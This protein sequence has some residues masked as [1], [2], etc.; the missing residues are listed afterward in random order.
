MRGIAVRYYLPIELIASAILAAIT[1]FFVVAASDLSTTWMILILGALVAATATFW[2]GDITRVLL[3]GFAFA[4]AFDLQKSLIA[5]HGNVSPGLS[6]YPPDVFLAP[7]L[8]VWLWQKMVIRRERFVAPVGFKTATLFYLWTWVTALASPEWY[9]GILA[10]LVVTRYF[11]AYI[12]LADIIRDGQTFRGVLL[13]I[14]LALL[15]N[16]A[17]VSAQFV[18]RS[19]LALQGAK[20][21]SLGV[22]LTFATEGVS[23][24][25]PA[26]FLHHPNVMANYLVLLLP[27]LMGLVFLGA[28]RVGR[29]VWLGAMTLLFGG[30]VAL[31]LTMS[32]GGWIAFGAAALLYLFFGFRKGLVKAPHLSNI[33]LS[34]VLGLAA[35]GVV[36]PSAYLRIFGGD[37]R[38]TESRMAMADQAFLIFRRNPILGCGLGYYNASAQQNIPQSFTRLGTGY[39][40]TLLKGVCHNKWLLLAAEQGAIG[41]ILQVAILAV[42]VYA[43][44]KV[45]HWRDPVYYAIG[46]GLACSIIGEGVFYV[47]DHFYIDVRI[48]QCWLAFGLLAALIRLHQNGQGAATPTRPRASA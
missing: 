5:P 13:A 15:A 12:V 11:L 4:S 34:L 36:Y 14:G 41:V 32:R 43:F 19:Q 18:T 40:Q 1:A 22:N 30:L 2:A 46:L 8:V 10:A 31:L 16:L 42:F 21:T 38:S 29:T 45:K 33:A 17:M 39:Q 3:Y 47:F 26:G 9:D 27:T 7:L 37:Q 44:F 23:I 48:F 35:I 24:F 25:R 28:P 20:P 6:L